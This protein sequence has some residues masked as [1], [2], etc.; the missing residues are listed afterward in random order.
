MLTGPH[1]SQSKLYSHF[2][3]S[4]QKLKHE[5]YVEWTGSVGGVDCSCH[6]DVDTDSTTAFHPG[7]IG[8]MTADCSVI[9]QNKD[10][11]VFLRVGPTMYR[12]VLKENMDLLDSLVGCGQRA[13]AGVD[14]AEPHHSSIDQHV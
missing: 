12:H 11:V 8:D 4:K 14:M 5:L 10:T 6:V 3:F 2:Q 13:E 1:E 9:G 7:L